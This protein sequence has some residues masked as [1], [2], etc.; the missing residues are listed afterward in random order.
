MPR[1][2][3]LALAALVATA[4]AAMA[5]PD[6]ALTFMQRFSG[7]WLGTG[8]LL[9]GPQVGTKFHCALAG[10]PSRTQMTLGMT[11]KCWMGSLSA[12]VYANIRYNEE[13][14]RFY[15]AFM[16]GAAGNGV[17]L[18]GSQTDKGVSLR[19]VRGP[20][21]GS[22]V[23][24][25][26]GD[27]QMKVVLSLYD[28]KNDRHIPVAAMGFTRKEASEMGLPNIDLSEFDASSRSRLANVR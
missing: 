4:P 20:A 15:G 24:E 17:D 9:I 19:L 1:V 2:P 7:E 21:Q 26:I 10:D 14:A 3:A 23:A 11:G 27:K 12:P 13:T 22:M 5:A 18:M 16:D 6:E 28:R 8:Q 25:P